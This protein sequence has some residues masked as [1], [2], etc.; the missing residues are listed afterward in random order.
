MNITEKRDFDI[1]VGFSEGEFKAIQHYAHMLGFS[2]VSGFI[3][4]HLSDALIS[5]EDK[6]SALARITD[7]TRGY[8][9]RVPERG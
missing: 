9:P 2:S 7:S 3:R 5:S 8:L 1:R 6:V 4:F